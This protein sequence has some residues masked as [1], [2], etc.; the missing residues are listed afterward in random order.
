[1][2][3]LQLYAKTTLLVPQ[4]PLRAPQKHL[5][6]LQLY[7]KTTFLVP[8]DLLKLTRRVLRISFSHWFLRVQTAVDPRT[9]A[10]KCCKVLRCQF[11]LFLCTSCFHW[12]LAVK[13]ALG[14]SNGSPNAC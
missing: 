11:L 3:S 8:Q 1:M 10:Y 13:H 4:T 7:A 9:A 12:Y 14:P 6:S 5:I 2:I